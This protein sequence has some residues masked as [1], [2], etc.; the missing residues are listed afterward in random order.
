MVERVRRRRYHHFTLGGD[1]VVESEEI[2]ESEVERIECLWCQRSD[3]IEMM[4]R[5]KAGG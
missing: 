5:T 4:I 1:E 3:G 2:L